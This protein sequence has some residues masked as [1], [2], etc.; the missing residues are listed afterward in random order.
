MKMK[1]YIVASM[2]AATLFT[3]CGDDFLNEKMVATITQDYFETEIGLEQ[4][5]VGTYSTLRV[6]KQ[7]NQG[8]FALLTGVDN[9]TCRTATYGMYSG[10]VW[11]STGNEA[12][13][14]NAL[15]GELT[16]SQLLGYYPCINDANRVIQSIDDGKAQG[17]FASDATYA[18]M[19]KS[20]ALFNRAYSIYM[21]N[22]LLG[23]VYVPLQYTQSLPS[24]Y[25]YKRETS[26]NLYKQIIGDLRYAFNHLSTAA[27]LGS[28]NFGRITKGAAAHFL[29]KLYLQ[30]AQSTQYGTAAYGRNADGSIDNTNEKSYLGMLY[31]GDV[32]T[33]LDSCLH[34]ANYVIA[35]DGYYKLETDYGKIFAHPMDDY[36]NEESREI[37]LACVY[38]MPANSGNNGRYGN[39]L[40]AFM[41]PVYTSASWGI[42]DRTWENAGNANSTVALSNDFGFDI[43]TNKHADSRFQKSFGIEYK[44]A[45]RGGT[46]SSVPAPDVDY[47]AYNNS[48]NAT[49][50]WTADMANYFNENVWAGY[51]RASWGGRKAVAGEHKM[52][53]GDIAFAFIENTKATAITIEE[54]L[55]QPFVIRARWIKDGDKY[56]YR[57]PLKSNGSSYTYDSGTY[58]GLDKLVSASTPA[59]TKYI[60]PNRNAYDSYYSS[61]DVPLFRIAETYLIRAAAYGY[62]G[63]YS[64]AIQDINAV[65]VRAA[66]K[67]GETR[68]EVIARLY[69][70]AENL[71]TVERSWPYE[72]Q[73]DMSTA[74][75]IDAT[76]FD[77]SS[78]NAK[79]EKYPA[80]A[81][82]TAD[83][84][85]NFILNEVAR[86]M[87][88]EFIYYEWL[89]HSGW[90]YDRVRFHDQ[91]GSSEKGLWDSADNLVGGT[92]PTGNGL[93]GFKPAYTLKPFR[94]SLLDLLTDENNT[95][96]DADSKKAY[97]NYG[98]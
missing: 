84:F 74:M 22:T 1:K 25:A 7:Y 27:E 49:Y 77:G 10:S 80:T 51:D 32:S 87:N 4:L 85:V 17:K 98:Y 8:P 63:N 18:Q 31:K 21:M 78:A 12:N 48:K 46:V 33:D 97:Q 44:T 60:D 15:C 2:I 13:Y 59:T 65:R 95:L 86:E 52:G 54:A 29:A 90:Q 73:D 39:R 47:H 64:N 43:Y 38:G 71:P 62:K 41:S 92:G 53:S 58:N 68:N 50:T 45:L 35:Q 79:A 23:D 14:T 26:E 83:Y 57:V 76:Y 40:N 5:I 94:Q 93:G 28:S 19:R 24:N 42:P 81:S 67:T 6:T 89:H 72:V 75:K 70:G 16:S 55:A 91:L 11:N 30:R 82:S 66:Y 3:S 88:S 34:F 36:S 96:L 20:E 61:R 37:I 56:Y 9:M 69:P